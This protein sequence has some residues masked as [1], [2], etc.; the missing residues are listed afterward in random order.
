MGLPL[1]GIGVDPGKLIESIEQRFSSIGGGVQQ[2]L[3]C[4]LKMRVHE[5]REICR[6]R[7]AFLRPGQTLADGL[8]CHHDDWVLKSTALQKIRT[9]LDDCPQVFYMEAA[10]DSCAEF[11]FH[12]RLISSISK[13]SSSVKIGM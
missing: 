1:Q 5:L 3:D 8:Y 12:S 13:K 2:F 9:Q 7:L 6:H 4:G 11:L 10:C